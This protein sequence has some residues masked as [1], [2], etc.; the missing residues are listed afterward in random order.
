[1]TTH[2]PLPDECAAAWYAGEHGDREGPF[3]RAEMI[4]SYLAGAL[5]QVRRVA[6]EELYG[7]LYGAYTDGTIGTPVISWSELPETERLVWDK[8][9]RGQA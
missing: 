8:I 1:M 9:A 3:C 5:E 4:A 7:R 2:E 6:G